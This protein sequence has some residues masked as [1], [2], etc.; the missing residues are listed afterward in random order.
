MIK[1]GILGAFFAGALCT[2]NTAS[3]VTISYYLGDTASYN[4]SCNDVDAGPNPDE[5]ICE[6]GGLSLHIAGY[7]YNTYTGQVDTSKQL[8]LDQGHSLSI[9]SYI[10]NYGQDEALVLTF[11]QTVTLKSLSFGYVDYNDEVKIGVLSSLDTAPSPFSYYDIPGYNWTYLSLPGQGRPELTG[12]MF[13]IGTSNDCRY[14]EWCD[15]DDWTLK[16]VTVDL[17]LS[18]DPVLSPVPL[19]AAGLMLLFGLL[20]MGAVRLRQRA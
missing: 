7:E 5:A 13:V 18:S 9:G 1:L 11:G 2:A 17:D 4:P 16:Y 10:D 12:D 8:D 14:S 19:P 3:A 6:S 15:N 20:G